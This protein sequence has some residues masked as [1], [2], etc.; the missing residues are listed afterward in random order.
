MVLAG[1]QCILSCAKEY[2]NLPKQGYTCCLSMDG[3]KILASGFDKDEKVSLIQIEQLVTAMGGVLHT[4][5]SQ[6]VNFV[7]VKNVLAAKYKSPSEVVALAATQGH[8]G[9][10]HDADVVHIHLMF[11]MVTLTSIQDTIGISLDDQLLHSFVP[12]GAWLGQHDSVLGCV[13][14][15]FELCLA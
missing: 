5:A 15:S 6:D 11:T 1:P 7:I 13:E 3:V 8:G 10:D 4:K 2:R 14:P 12:C 9:G